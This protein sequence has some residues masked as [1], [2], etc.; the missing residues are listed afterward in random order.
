[1]NLATKSDPRPRVAS[2]YQNHED[3][4]EGDWLNGYQKRG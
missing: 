1:M 4:Q 3:Q 2:H